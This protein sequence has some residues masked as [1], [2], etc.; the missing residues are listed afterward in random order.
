MGTT[1]VVVPYVSDTDK[2]I[3]YAI[4]DNISMSL[5]VDGNILILYRTQLRAITLEKTLEKKVNE[6]LNRFCTARNDSLLPSSV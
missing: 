5:L 6:K 4:Y 1:K 3:N 2:V